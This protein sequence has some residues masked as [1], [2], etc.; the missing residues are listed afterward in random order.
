MR[1]LHGRSA[2]VNPVLVED[3]QRIY[4]TQR[5]DDQLKYYR[6]Q[7]QRALPLLRSLR[8]TFWIATILAMVCVASYAITLSMQI[9]A[10]AWLETTVFNFLP[11]SLPVAAAAT[12]SIISINDLQR[13]VARY[14]DMQAMLEA[15][16]AQIVYCSTWNSLEKVVL[17]T[18]RA[19]LQEV[20]EWHSLAN[21][22]E[23]H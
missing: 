14:R 15:S 1:I 19:L 6:R 10:P 9:H 8:R 5:I 3:F 23:S 21:F 20:I 18:E 7:E 22:S 12:I 4:R 2:R 16:T 17:R 11:V 13:R